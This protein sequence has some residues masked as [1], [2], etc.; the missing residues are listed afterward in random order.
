MQRCTKSYE[1]TQPA[2]IWSSRVTPWMLWELC[3][4]GRPAAPQPG[5][6]MNQEAWIELVASNAMPLS[7]LSLAGGSVRPPGHQTNNRTGLLG[8]E[9]AARQQRKVI[10][11]RIYSHARNKVLTGLQQFYCPVLLLHF[12][13]FLALCI[14]DVSGWTTSGEP[15]TVLSRSIA[16]PCI[17]GSCKM[18]EL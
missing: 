1:F 7:P 2:G 3:S 10:I 18:H 13:V 9:F 17:L 12:V 5:L 4:Q 15:Y 6:L 16:G 11:Q 14:L 8:W